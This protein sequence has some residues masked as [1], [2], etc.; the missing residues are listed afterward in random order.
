MRDV[1]EVQ[2]R[3]R[4]QLE[5]FVAAHVADGELVGL[6][7][8]CPHHET[9]EPVCDILRLAHV[10]Q[11]L[12]DF[13]GGFDA[14]EDD[15]RAAGEPLLVAGGERV[16]PY[17]RGELFWAQYLAHAVGENFGTGA[18]NGTETCRLENVEQLVKGDPVEDGDADEFYGRKSADFHAHFLREHFQNVGIVTERKRLV[19][20]SLQENLVG[21]PGL[22]FD[23]FL[24]D[25]VQIKHVGFGAVGGT[26]ET[27]KAAGNLADVRVV[28][29]AESRVAHLVPRV[30]A[31]AHRVA[32]LD[33]LGPR[34]VFQDV[35]SFRRGE[36]CPVNRFFQ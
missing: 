12:D 1:V 22:G 27:A 29:D 7:L 11:M 21:A 20:A 17:L 24:T 13:F 18:R 23:R 19:H 26:A 2:S 16:A 25:F 33:H 32:G 34:G 9:L 4:E 5:V 14:A 31:V 36:A 30:D 10:I 35:K 15:I 8:E 6:R 3:K 28:D